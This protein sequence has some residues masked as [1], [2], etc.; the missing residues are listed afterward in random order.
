MVLRC[1]LFASVAKA[2]SLETRVS[3]LDCQGIAILICCKTS[4][5]AQCM[6]LALPPK[7][8]PASAAAHRR[9]A[10]RQT[11]GQP[12]RHAFFACSALQ[13]QVEHM[14]ALARVLSH[15]CH[16]FLDRISG[17]A[18]ETGFQAQSAKSYYNREGF[19]TLSLGT[20]FQDRVSK[21][22]FKTEVQ[23]T[24]SI[25]GVKLSTES[26]ETGFQGIE[27]DDKDKG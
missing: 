21:Q 7:D 19:K 6:Q 26:L 14:P 8:R 4:A 10:R 23:D 20:G 12:A 25:N 15:S 9:P 16:D 5:M 13:R 17:Q 27:R 11:W 18:F 22:S 3:L 1:A 2:L 24:V